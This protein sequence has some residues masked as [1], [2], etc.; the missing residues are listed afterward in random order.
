MEDSEFYIA[1]ANLLLKDPTVLLYIA[2]IMAGRLVA[3]DSSLVETK[4]QLRA[5]QTPPSFGEMLNKF[6]EIFSGT[7]TQSRHLTFFRDRGAL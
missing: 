4:K 7:A 5:G 3:A 2:T 1:D 6:E